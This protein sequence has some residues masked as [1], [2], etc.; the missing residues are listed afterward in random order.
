MMLPALVI[1]TY[2]LSNGTSSLL[3]YP[4]TFPTPT[5]P[6]FS[7]GRLSSSFVGDASGTRNPPA[8]ISS[9]SSE[10]IA[11]AFFTRR[12]TASVTKAFT[13]P[14]VLL[15]IAFGGRHLT[16]ISHGTSRLAISVKFALSPKS[17]FHLLSLFPHRSFAKRIQTQCTCQP[18]KASRISC[19][20]AAHFPHGLNGGC[21]EGKLL[22]PWVHSFLRRF[23]VDG[24]ESKK[25][26]PTT[27]R[28]SSRP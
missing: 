16:K 1:T 21:S 27:A 14:A 19:R 10:Q 17:Y 15:Q 8:V 20:L 26:S 6:A 23:C 13:P 24:E 11:F 9:Y 25:S 2:G 4:P 5:M 12:T 7:N 28:P 22:A 3:L 18:L